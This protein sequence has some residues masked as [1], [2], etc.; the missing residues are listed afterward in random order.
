MLLKAFSFAVG[1][2][3]AS[4]K[5]TVKSHVGGVSRAW[6]ATFQELHW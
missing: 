4:S 6:L 1:R 5:A 2:N 3:K